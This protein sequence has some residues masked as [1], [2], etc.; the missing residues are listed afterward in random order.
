MSDGFLHLQIFKG[1]LGSK[2]GLNTK[3][4]KWDY[5]VGQVCEPTK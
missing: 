1:S 3:K 5:F 2:P 4:L